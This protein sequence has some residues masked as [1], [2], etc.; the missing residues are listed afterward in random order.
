MKINPL[1]ILLFIIAITFSVNPAF[2][3]QSTTGTGST[4]TDLAGNSVTV[5]DH[6]ERVVITSMSPMVPIY[7]YY[8]NSTDT[9][10]GANSAGI[11]YAKSG[12]MSKIYPGLK[13]VNTGF[14]QGVEINIEEILKLKP[15]VVLYTGSRKDEYKILSDANLT[16][17]GFTTSNPEKDNNVFSQMEFWLNQLAQITGDTGKADSL[18]EYNKAVQ[19][20]VADKIASV[21][22][23]KK[24]KALIIFSYKDGKLQVAGN[25]HYS[26]YWLNATGAEN[27]ASDLTGL[28]EVDMEQVIAWNPDI[29]YFAN[30]QSALPSDLYNNTISGSDWST[31]SAV[32]NKQVYIFPYA[33]YMSYAPSLENG[34][35]LEWMAQKNHPELFSD[36]NMEEETADFFK[37]FFNYTA[38]D[39]DIKGFLN[40]ESIAVRLH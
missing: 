22:A 16:A 33:T 40:P 7:V 24:P 13:D 4:F 36:L 34:L 5:P 20:K 14:I 29:I 28:K 2:A 23:E 21:D 11:T 9:L 31:I 17:V 19:E 8:T 35:V 26:E 3:S 39:E 27:V 1:F 15:D 37:K 38:S 30:S 25:G 18:V 10:F 6:V 12:V 32:K